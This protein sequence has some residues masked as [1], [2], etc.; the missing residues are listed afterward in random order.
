MQRAVDHLH[1]TQVGDGEMIEEC[2]IQCSLLRPQSKL[3]HMFVD[4]LSMPARPDIPPSP[5]DT[6]V[7]LQSLPV[8]DCTEDQIR[9]WLE[10]FGSVEDMVIL[11]HNGVQTGKGYVRFSKHEEAAACVEA[12]AS[13]ADA[14]QGDVVAHWSE[15]ERACQTSNVYGSDLHLAF[16]VNALD[17]VRKSTGI[18]GLW[19]LS[20]RQHGAGAPPPVAK[21]LHF[22]LEGDEEQIVGV[23]HDLSQLLEDFHRHAK[24]KLDERTWRPKETTHSEPQVWDSEWGTQS[25][26]S[27]GRSA[28]QGVWR[29]SAEGSAGQ[30]RTGEELDAVKSSI[31]RGEACIREGK[32]CERSGPARKAYDQYRRGLQIL[33]D[34]MQKLGEEDPIASSLRLRVDTYLEDAEKLK[35]RIDA[36]GEKRGQ[37]FGP[38]RPRQG[39]RVDVKSKHS[40]APSVPPEKRSRPSTSDPAADKKALLAGRLER[41][42]SLIKE[43]RLAEEKNK[44]EEAYEKYCRGLQCIIEVMPQLDDDDP[45]VAP[46]REKVSDYLER[47]EKLNKKFEVAGTRRPAAEA[48]QGGSSRGPKRE[49]QKRST[50]SDRSRSR[51]HKKSRSRSRRRRERRRSRSRSGRKGAH[52]SVGEAARAL[53][54][55][56]APPVAPGPVSPPGPMLSVPWHLRPERKPPQGSAASVP[57]V[58]APRGPAAPLLRPKSGSALLVGKAASR[59]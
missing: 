10:G 26:R 8:R 44:T 59:R 36:E 30:E 28:G 27:T 20:E 55:S 49:S 54:Q 24:R 34:V 12:Q 38:E 37:T 22:I 50:R 48:S 23:K 35:A 45:Q 53:A 41:G 17:A 47:A 46:L 25:W 32:L 33:I 15:S 58:P 5:R 42:E 39:G 13:I 56:S 21:Q 7:F 3:W 19:A 57:P 11:S 52:G 2:T 14:E 43:G 9:A 4:E 31:E 51:R 16:D 40:R 1:N 18:R 29:P 6:E